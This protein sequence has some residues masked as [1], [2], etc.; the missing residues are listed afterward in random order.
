MVKID[1]LLQA[2][3]QVESGGR[4]NAVSP[5]GA[6]GRM[7]VMPATARQPGYKVKPAKNE[8]EEEYT[9]VGRDYAKA[10][11]KHYDGDLDSALVAYNYGPG[12]ANKWIAAGRDKRKLPE[13]TR[14]YITRVNKQLKQGTGEK[15]MAREF[16]AMKQAQLSKLTKQAIKNPD[17]PDARKVVKELLARY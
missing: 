8:S 3:E 2:I 9:R 10:L 4:R 13:E 1:R 11:L 5:K 12:N 17:S 6:R 15:K 16:E 7:Q 14:N